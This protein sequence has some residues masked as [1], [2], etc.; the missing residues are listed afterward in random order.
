MLFAAVGYPPKPAAQHMAAGSILV[1][2]LCD[3]QAC[4]T[5]PVPSSSICIEGAHWRLVARCVAT[6][7]LLSLADRQIDDAITQI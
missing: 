2:I 5:L 3:M 1:M 4:S 6:W 7:L